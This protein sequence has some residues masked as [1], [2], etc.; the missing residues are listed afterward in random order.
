M[1]A[2]GDAFQGAEDIGRAGLFKAI[3]SRLQ[4]GELYFLAETHWA[5][6]YRQSSGEVQA[7]GGLRVLGI[8]LVGALPGSREPASCHTSC[9]KMTPR[10]WVTMGRLGVRGQGSR[11]VLTGAQQVRPSAGSRAP[12][13]CRRQAAESELS[14]AV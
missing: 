13:P 5:D 10:S 4:E 14:A 2:E 3:F 9:S 6:R 8:A 7:A 1:Q 11:G 12:G